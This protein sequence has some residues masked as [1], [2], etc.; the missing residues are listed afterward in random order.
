MNTESFNQISLPCCASV[1][2][3]SYSTREVKAWPKKFLNMSLLS[4]LTWTND[5]SIFTVITAC[6]FHRGYAA[7]CLWLSWNASYTG[8]PDRTSPLSKEWSLRSKCSIAT[9]QI[10]A[11]KLGNMNEH[12]AHC[13]PLV[14]VINLKS[15]RAVVTPIDQSDIP[16]ALWKTERISTIFNCSIVMLYWNHKLR[17]KMLIQLDYGRREQSFKKA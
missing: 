2:I 7:L 10:S 8:I 15:A 5:P 6:C 14:F 1:L 16:V 4:F 13:A 9:T 11:H 17:I 12:I 3:P